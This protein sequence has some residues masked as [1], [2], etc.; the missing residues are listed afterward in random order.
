ME[1]KN[2][3]L[4][5]IKKMNRTKQEKV[6]N[7]VMNKIVTNSIMTKNI[8]WITQLSKDYFDNIMTKIKE[9]RL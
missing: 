3:K 1:I 7:I 9:A 6:L 8:R 2:S 4:L 5:K